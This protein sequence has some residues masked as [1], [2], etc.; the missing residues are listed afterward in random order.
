MTLDPAALSALAATAV[1]ALLPLLEKATAKGF[2]KL[3][4]ATAGT[5]FDKLKQRLTRPAAQEALEELARA[6]QDETNRG[7]VQLQLTKA[8]NEQPELAAELQAWLK[9]AGVD[10]AGTSQVMNLSGSGHKAV[11]VS[12]GSGNSVQIG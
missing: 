3:G 2:E 8:L 1:G 10:T 7:L 6:P 11:Q 4:E 5:L 12:G 9:E